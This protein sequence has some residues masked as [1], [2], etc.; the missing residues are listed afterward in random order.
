MVTLGKVFHVKFVGYANCFMYI[1]IS[2]LKEHYIP[3]DQARYARY[4][5][6]K[7][8]NTATIKLSSKFHKINSPHDMIF[9]K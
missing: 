6:T 4:V 7:Y 5:V 8:L 3:V 1:R 2:Q 9:T